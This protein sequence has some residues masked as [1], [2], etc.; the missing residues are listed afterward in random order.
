MATEI[1]FHKSVEKEPKPQLGKD[2]S[3]GIYVQVGTDDDPVIL[4]VAAKGKAVGV[5]AESIEIAQSYGWLDE[6][7][8]P[9]TKR[10]TIKLDP[11]DWTDV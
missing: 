4:F 11:V 9:L 2:L 6:S 8:V 10:V 7:F 3:P 1:T 5:T